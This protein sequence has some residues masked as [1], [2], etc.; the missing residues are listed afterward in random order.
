[1]TIDLQPPA[2]PDVG[3]GAVAVA[4]IGLPSRRPWPRMIRRGDQEFTGG[5]R[6]RTAGS[7]SICRKSPRTETPFR[8]RSRS[9]A[10]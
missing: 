5:R 10:R 9:T 7:S 6:Q 2:G 3:A 1:M 8:S 4:A